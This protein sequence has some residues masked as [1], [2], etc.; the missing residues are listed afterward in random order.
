MEE[1]LCIKK[2]LTMIKSQID[3]LL[4][5]LERMDPQSQESSGRGVAHSPLHGS[6]SS[7]D[8]SS[9]D[10]PPLKTDRETQSPQT[11]DSS[12]EDRE[13]VNGYESHLLYM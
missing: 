8:G 9:G 10:S 3:E 2:E 11:A 4:D 13:H 5:N 1:L 7:V 12:D 6:V